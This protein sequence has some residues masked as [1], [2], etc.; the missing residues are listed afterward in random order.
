MSSQNAYI[1]KLHTQMNDTANPRISY[2]QAYVILTYT[3]IQLFVYPA[4]G[5]GSK[6]KIINIFNGKYFVFSL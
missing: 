3:Y 4:I 6:P 1:F 5:Y 2:S